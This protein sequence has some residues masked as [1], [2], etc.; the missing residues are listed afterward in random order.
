M[1]SL[2]EKKYKKLFKSPK[3]F[4]SLVSTL[5]EIFNSEQTDEDKMKLVDAIL[6]IA[7]DSLCRVCLL[8]DQNE[9]P[10]YSNGLCKKHYHQKHSLLKGRRGGDETLPPPKSRR[11]QPDIC[12]E[13]GCDRD[14]YCRGYCSHHYYSLVLKVKKEDRPPI[15]SKNIYPT[16]CTVPGCN[17][18]HFS[19]GY[20]NLHCSRV[21][22]S[23]LDPTD[24]EAMNQPLRNPGGIYKKTIGEYMR[25]ILLERGKNTVCIDD[26]DELLE[27]AKRA[28][29][30]SRTEYGQQPRKL[31]IKVIAALDMS[32]L[33]ETRYIKKV[34]RRPLRLLVLKEFND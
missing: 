5:T 23:G 7:T 13:P 15:K 25:D 1:T 26:L 9:Q 33:F 34:G 22:R 18:K 16:T 8:D 21:F 10:S 2:N 28:D 4:S 19:R 12:T 14:H 17:E 24:L 6:E 32:R 30:K 27:C 20:C 3:R 29:M 31:I 11:L